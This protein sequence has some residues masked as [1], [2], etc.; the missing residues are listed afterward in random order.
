[1]NLD[2]AF[3]VKL[4]KSIGLGHFIRLVNLQKK[5]SLKDVFWIIS[6]DNKIIYSHLKKKKNIFKT[7]NFQSTRILK[8]LKSRNINKIIMDLSSN[9][10]LINN[11]IYKIQKFYKKNNFKIVSFDIPVQ[12]KIISDLSII[13]YEVSDN[14]IKSSKTELMIGTNFFLNGKK[15]YYKNQLIKKK[16]NKILICMSGTDPKNISFKIY[17]YIKHLPFSFEVIVGNNFNKIQLKKKNINKKDKIYKNVKDI[18]NKI[19]KADA[20]ICGEGLI[21]YETVFQKKPTILIHQYDNK[22]SMIKNFLKTNTCLS[23]GLFDRLS[24]QKASN[25]IKSYLRNISLIRKNIKNMNKHFDYQKN[26]F[27]NNLMIKKIT[28]I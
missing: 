7:N 19:S 17:K 21:K 24:P 20:V 23:L 22:S 13:P 27:K 16:I 6:G 8:I 1:M 11:K 14:I 4:S 5:F 9:E 25:K 15:E 28:N 18:S 10:Y 26:E 2:I 12:K 3:F